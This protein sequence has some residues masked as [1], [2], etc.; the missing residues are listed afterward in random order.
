[1]NFY[2]VFTCTFCTE[3]FGVTFISKPQLENLTNHLSKKST[4]HAN[5]R[6]WI[7]AT[8]FA[9]KIHRGLRR[10]LDDKSKD[11]DEA[12][13][14]IITA[15]QSGCRPRPPPPPLS[16]TVPTCRTRSG[17]SPR[18]TLRSCSPSFTAMTAE[19]KYITFYRSSVLWAQSSMASSYI[20]NTPINV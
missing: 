15:D 13:G 2:F 1:M 20:N 8:Q 14:R 19:G 4:L 6:K 7:F 3:Y 17:S 9:V 12:W 5:I 10:Y 11:F 18:G 16:R